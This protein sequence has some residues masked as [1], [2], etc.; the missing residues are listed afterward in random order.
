MEENL[1]HQHGG[2][3]AGPVLPGKAAL[4]GCVHQAAVVV[5][6]GV[7]G[8]QCLVCHRGVILEETHAALVA[9]AERFPV[10]IDAH[11]VQ[12]LEVGYHY[13]YQFG[14]RFVQVHRL[15]SQVDFQG[16]VLQ[17][18]F[19]VLRKRSVCGKVVVPAGHEVSHDEL[20][21]LLRLFVALDAD[22]C[23]LAARCVGRLQIGWKGAYC[24]VL[25]S[26]PPF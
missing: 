2:H 14:D 7:R 22:H 1:A 25:Y 16:Y 23:G 19:D 18:P 8:T 12:D 6:L 20:D 21:D 15:H 17:D 4:D 9:R 13:G 26:Y 11:L 24:H 10:L 5:G 3:A